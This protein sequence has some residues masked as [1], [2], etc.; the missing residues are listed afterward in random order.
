MNHAID[1]YDDSDVEREAIDGLQWTFKCCGLEDKDDWKP[2]NATYPPSCCPGFE[3]GKTERCTNPHQKACLK[4][5]EHYFYYVANSAAIAGI[6][7]A[8]VQLAAIISS[9]LLAKSFRKHYNY[10]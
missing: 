2:V 7:V 3:K 8:I 9:C 4:E 1:H 5:V 10:V 6:I